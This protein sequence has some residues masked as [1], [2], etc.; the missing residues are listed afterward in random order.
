MV[1][2]NFA[3]EIVEINSYVG[4]F[5][6]KNP[7][8]KIYI[9]TDSQSKGEFTMYITVVVLYIPTK[10]GHVVYSRTLK[11]RK[12]Y[13]K[14]SGKDFHKLY[15]ESELSLGVANSI[16]E[17]TGIKADYIELDYNN[18]P[19]YFSNTVLVQTLGWIRSLGYEVK[20]KPDVCSTYMADKLVKGKNYHRKR[21][22]RA[23]A[24]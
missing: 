2:K 10:G 7:N 23:I 12:I 11:D 13:G 6:E 15:I 5:V 18:D 22:K 3:G 1:F 16:L 20:F 4:A 8:T 14:A 21:K 24:V 17:V 19:R 9:S